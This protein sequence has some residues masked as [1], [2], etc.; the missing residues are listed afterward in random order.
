[1][2]KNDFITE[3]SDRLN[4]V[5]RASKEGYKIPSI[6]RHRLEGFIQAGVFMKVATQAEMSKLLED[7]HYSIFEKTIQGRKLEKTAS[8]SDFNINYE[9]FDTPI[10]LRE[11]DTSKRP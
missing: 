2:D 3:V 8:W 9:K 11:S 4:K 1:M 10:F 6:E 5:F 7:T